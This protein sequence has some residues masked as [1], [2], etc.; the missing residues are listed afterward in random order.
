MIDKTRIKN[1]YLDSDLYLEIE[2]SGKVDNNAAIRL[3]VCRGDIN[4]K[5]R[6]VEGCIRVN[7]NELV[8]VLNKT[9]LDEVHYSE[10]G[11]GPNLKCLRKIYE[12]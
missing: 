5:T 3:I 7:L 1:V 4:G 9:L 10:P 8:R 2:S 11:V 12:D 6:V